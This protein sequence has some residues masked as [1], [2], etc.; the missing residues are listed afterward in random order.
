[1]SSIAHIVTS[2]QED[3]PDYDEEKSVRLLKELETNIGA[4][5]VIL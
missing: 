4:E 1:M 5:N 3:H 2:I